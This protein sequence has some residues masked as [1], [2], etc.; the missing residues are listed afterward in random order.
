M[1]G[2]PLTS[3]GRCPASATS[4]R[5]SGV[6]H[7]LAKVGV[8]GSNPFARSTKSTIYRVKLPATATNGNQMATI[9]WPNCSAPRRCI[10]CRHEDVAKGAIVA[11]GTDRWNSRHHPASPA[12]KKFA[13]TTRLVVDQRDASR[14]RTRLADHR[15]RHFPFA[16]DLSWATV[17]PPRWALLSV[18]AGADG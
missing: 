17:R 1:L 6:E 12:P 3:A 18:L 10:L 16:Y 7:N 14:A 2:A 13:A 4:G 9:T 8:E 5:S 11:H 15:S